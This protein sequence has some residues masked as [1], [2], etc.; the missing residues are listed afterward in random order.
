M[1]LSKLVALGNLLKL[2]PKLL[3]VYLLSKLSKLGFFVR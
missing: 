1:L 2:L 3:N